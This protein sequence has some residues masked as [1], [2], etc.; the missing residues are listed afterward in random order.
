MMPGDQLYKRRFSL[1]HPDGLDM[2]IDEIILGK[3]TIWI[4]EIEYRSTDQQEI[5]IPFSGAIPLHDQPQYAG[6]VL[7]SR[8]QRES[9]DSPSHI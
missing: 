9:I 6:N 1:K 8:Y 7:A 5:P 4:A 3:E 2:G